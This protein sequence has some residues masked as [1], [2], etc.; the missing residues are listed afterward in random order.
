VFGNDRASGAIEAAESVMRIA[1][2]VARGTI[3]E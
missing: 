1:S 2:E 3:R